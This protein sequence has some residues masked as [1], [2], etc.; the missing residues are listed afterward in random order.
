MEK[1]MSNLAPHHLLEHLLLD[2]A[3]NDLSMI[4]QV[5]KLTFP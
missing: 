2:I 3:R 4:N 1:Q 5:N